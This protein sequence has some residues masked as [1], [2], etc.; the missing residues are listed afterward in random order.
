MPADEAPRSRRGSRCRAFAAWSRATAQ[1]GRSLRRQPGRA[2]VRRQRSAAR[3]WRPRARPARIIS[4]ARRSG[5]CC[6]RSIR[7]D[8]T[9]S[10]CVER[11]SRRVEQ[12]RARLR[13]VLRALQ[14]ARLAGDARSEPGAVPDPGHRHA[15]LRRRTRRRRA[16]PREFYVNTINV[17]RWAEGVSTYRG[18]PEQ[19]AFDIEYW[20]LEEAKLQRCRSPR[21]SRADRARHRRRRRH[22]R[23]DGAAAAG[24]R[25]VRRCSAISIG[26]RSTA[27]EAALRKAYGS[28]R[29]AQL[30]GGRHATKTP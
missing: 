23:G 14:A 19:E 5:R 22:R 28:D 25:R 3:R 18:L 1:Q 8:E 7:H 16:S 12:Y 13:R 6:C 21:R 4:C 10:S 2:R 20:L 26:T 15:R 9:P 30:L 29:V 17:M 24:R 11:F 27:A